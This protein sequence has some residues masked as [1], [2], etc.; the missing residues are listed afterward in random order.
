M[1]FYSVEIK[2]FKSIFV[3]KFVYSANLRPGYQNHD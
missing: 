1:S 2:F 3:K